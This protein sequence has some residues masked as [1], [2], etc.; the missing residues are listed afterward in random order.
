MTNKS[1][2]QEVKIKTL[3]HFEH[4]DNFVTLESC[5]GNY[6]VNLYTNGDAGHKINP[7][8]AKTWESTCLDVAVEV[9]NA[10]CKGI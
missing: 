6:T 4:G 9:Y 10:T 2:Y 7:V 8:P 1:E 5:S 3:K